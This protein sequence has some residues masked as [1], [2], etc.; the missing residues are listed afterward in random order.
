MGCQ[1]TVGR[2]PRIAIPALVAWITVHASDWG[3]PPGCTTSANRGMP[4][5][6]HRRCRLPEPLAVRSPPKHALEV[7]L[8]SLVSRSSHSTWLLWFADFQGLYHV[9]QANLI[10]LDGTSPAE[11]APK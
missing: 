8:T 5:P 11:A 7:S 2:R 9:G 6:A 1:R 3:H 10:V 4:H